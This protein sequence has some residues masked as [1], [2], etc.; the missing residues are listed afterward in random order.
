MLGQ[1]IR[2]QR[3][4]ERWLIDE[5]VTRTTSGTELYSSGLQSKVA[6]LRKIARKPR[7]R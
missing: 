5:I 3:T 7:R 1:T 2:F 6:D 4:G